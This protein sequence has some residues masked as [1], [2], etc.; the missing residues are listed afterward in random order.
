MLGDLFIHLQETEKETTN[1]EK[2]KFYCCNSLQT[3]TIVRIP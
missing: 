1:D 3:K 2:L